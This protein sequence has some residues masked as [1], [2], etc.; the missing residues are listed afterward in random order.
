[1]TKTEWTEILR[2][3]PPEDAAT[4]AAAH[5]HWARLAK[6]LGGLVI[7]GLC[8]VFLGGALYRVPIIMDGFIS[9][10]AALCA[11]RLCENA[12]KAVFA[13][14]VSS[15]PAAHLVLNAL[16]KKPLLTAGMHLGEGT[17]AVAS[18]PLWDM[19]IAVYQGCYSFSEGGIE[20][21]KPQC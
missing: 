20:P 8:G 11:V 12:K 13:S 10:V 6:P 15:E 9:G 2:A 21:Y 7:A 5:E 16:C 17:G 1:M 19:A 4:R 3:I 18:I 14:H